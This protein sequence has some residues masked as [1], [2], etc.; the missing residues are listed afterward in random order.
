MSVKNLLCILLVCSVTL[1]NGCGQLIASQTAGLA[2]ELSDAMLNHDDPQTVA[3]AIPTFLV[4]LDAMS[5]GNASV[6]T[7]LSAARLYT[8][9]A[10]TFVDDPSRQQRLANH[11]WRHAKTALCDYEEDWCK[12]PNAEFTALPE[13]LKEADEDDIDVLYGVATA[14]LG[15]IQAFSGDWSQVAALPKVQALLERSVALDETYDYGGAHL[16]LGAI[17]TLLP[18][19]VGGKPEVAREHFERVLAISEGKHLMAKVEYARRYARLIFDKELHHRLL[20][21]VLATDIH[22]EGLTLANAMAH[23]Q[24]Q[25]LL[26]DEN[27]YF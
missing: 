9:Y 16:Y 5:A 18:P 17:A 27:D 2:Q 25:L 8:A 6:A 23:E 24:A 4:T 14:W 7:H 10:G 21:E 11:A 13:A 15:F 26:D 22:V 3:A 12:W 20:T 19:A 1:L